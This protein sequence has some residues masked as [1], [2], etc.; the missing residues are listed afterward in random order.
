MKASHVRTAALVGTLLVSGA[1][2]STPMAATFDEPSGKL[3]L[4]GDF[5]FGFEDGADA[6][7]A[8]G[9]DR[10]L[11]AEPLVV[12][13]D[14]ALEG[15][16]VLMLGEEVQGVVLDL[17]S[18][19]FEGR[20]VEIRAWY[21]AIGRRT[22]VFADWPS[23]EGSYRQ[24]VGRIEMRD[25]G[26]ATDDGWRELTSGEVDFELAGALRMREL[27]LLSGMGPAAADGVVLVDA[28]SISDIGVARV[29]AVRCNLINE[30]DTCGEGV[31]HFGVCTD[32]AQVRGQLPPEVH[33]ADYI[34]RRMFEI[35]TFDGVRRAHVGDTFR[36][37]MEAALDA[38][39]RDF[40]PLV[41][42]AYEST[43][44]GH[45][46]PPLAV[47]LPRQPLGVCLHLAE[48]DLMPGGGQRPMVLT[49]DGR[50]DFARL[51]EP[52]DIL[53]EVD[54]IPFAQWYDE[55]RE[56]N[57]FYYTGDPAAEE[58]Q[59]MPDVIRLA[60]ETGA[61]MTFERCDKDTPCTL[62]ELEIIEVDTHEKG[63]LAML[64]GRAPLWSDEH[65]ICDHRFDREVLISPMEDREGGPTENDFVRHRDADGIRHLLFNGFPSG[66]TSQEWRDAI[67]EALSDGP[68]RI[69]IDERLGYGGATTQTQWLVGFLIQ[70]GR[71]IGAEEYPWLEQNLNG[72]TVAAFREC[73]TRA[74]GLP[75]GIRYCGGYPVRFLPGDENSSGAAQDSKVAILTGLDVSNNDVFTEYM[76]LRRGPTRIFGPGPTWGA[77]GIQCPLPP[78]GGEYVTPG[79][80]CTDTWFVT[81]RNQA[82]SEFR[83]GRGVQPDE[84]VLQRQSDALAGR[85]TQIEA[86]REWLEAE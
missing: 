38:D 74:A 64:E 17:E 61:Q 58:I 19:G 44:D 11:P 76:S 69:M 40:W 82:L 70:R 83:S 73:E 15:T 29:E 34:A 68:E 21:K 16:H 33:R 9:L 52:G 35:E 78:Y 3:V 18:A 10:V 39:P 80:Q 43:N 63:G 67:E 71:F 51:L 4:D 79:F 77:F 62:G 72:A 37:N 60:W 27:L 32:V 57:L 7:T 55:A 25:T 49:V 50:I 28:I 23:G 26:R 81:D 65:R 46:Q 6:L 24:T 5:G 30:R 14:D 59:L 22:V 41:S 48:A 1:G 20:R 56:R 86:A 54:G 8:F 84:V 31:C 66:P 36:R 12:E 53:T 45:A 47:P 2:L 75:T 85:D 42:A 13:S